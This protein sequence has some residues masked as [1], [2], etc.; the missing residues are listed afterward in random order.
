VADILKT[1]RGSIRRAPLP[2]G[3]P[4]WE[5]IEQMTMDQIRSGAK[6]NLPGY[7]TI[8]K[9]LTDGRFNR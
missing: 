1:K 3:S 5:E 9:V 2:P 4:G 8:L 6:Q 7:K